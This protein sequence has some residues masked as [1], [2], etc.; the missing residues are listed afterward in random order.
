V[1]D[2][3]IVMLGVAACWNDPNFRAQAMMAMQA[4]EE[5]GYLEDMIYSKPK[6]PN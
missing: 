1:P 3:F 6:V 5:A 2:D 4:A